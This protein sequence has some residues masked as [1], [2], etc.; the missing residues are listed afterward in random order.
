MVYSQRKCGV[1]R[2][3]AVCTSDV[4]VCSSGRVHCRLICVN[5]SININLLTKRFIGTPVPLKRV[6]NMFFTK[7]STGVITQPYDSWAVAYM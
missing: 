3:Q 7:G 5:V 1:L 4:F 6:F 2:T